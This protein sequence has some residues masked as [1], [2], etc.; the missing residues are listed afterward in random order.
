[1]AGLQDFRSQ[2]PE[3]NDMPDKELADSLHA[4]FY[5]D[6]PKDQFDKKMGM[7]A[8]APQA[9]SKFD[10]RTLKDVAESGL[11][12]LGQGVAGLVGLPGTISDAMDTGLTGL[13]NRLTGANVQLPK[14]PLSGDV[15]SQKLSNV[16]GG[17]H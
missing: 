2:H 13:A 14:S 16:V 17:Y 3:Y 10:L 8:A 5:S 7:S 15:L 12:G 9:P 6:M 4:K 11:S 1:M